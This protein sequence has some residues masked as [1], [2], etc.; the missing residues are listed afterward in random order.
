MYYPKKKVSTFPLWILIEE[1]LGILIEGSYTLQFYHLWGL[2]GIRFLTSNPSSTLNYLIQF[3]PR[4]QTRPPCTI[5]DT[6]YFF[7][8]WKRLKKVG[9]MLSLWAATMGE[10]LLLLMVFLSMELMLACLSTLWRFTIRKKNKKSR[11]I[12]FKKLQGH[13]IHLLISEVQIFSFFWLGSCA[14]QGCGSFIV[15]QRID[16]QRLKSC[17]RWEGSFSQNQSTTFTL[18]SRFP[19]LCKFRVC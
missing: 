17:G 3:N 2:E 4:C 6:L 8:C 14:E 16:G 9:K 12:W 11:E 7:V 13:I 10:F 1:A 5:L 18:L 15:P 19:S